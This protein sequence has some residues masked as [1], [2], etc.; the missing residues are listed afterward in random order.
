MKRIIQALWNILV[1]IWGSITLIIFTIWYGK[2]PKV[3]IYH[4]WE[5]EKSFKDI[6]DPYWQSRNFKENKVDE[7]SVWMFKQY[8]LQDK[9]LTNLSFKLY[10][11][12][13]DHYGE[14]S[15]GSYINDK[16]DQFLKENK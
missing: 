11:E 15:F 9:R 3:S 4:M 2:L 10:D 8:L 7:G 6:F 13:G 14:A 12:E 16:V 5:S 1:C